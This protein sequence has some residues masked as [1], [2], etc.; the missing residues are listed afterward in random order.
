MKNNCKWSAFTRT[1]STLRGIKV[2]HIKEHSLCKT[3]FIHPIISLFRL[4]DDI[5]EN[6]RDILDD[7][8]SLGSE[9]D[10]STKKLDPRN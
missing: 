7:V 5:N 4:S 9:P 3:K 8:K 2:G 1:T 10:A 6:W